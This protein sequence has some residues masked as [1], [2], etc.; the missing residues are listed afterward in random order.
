MSGL[1]EKL[2]GILSN[3]KAMEQIMSLAQ[4]LGKSS[5]QSQPPASDTQSQPEQE[6]PPASEPSDSGLLDTL[7]QID[8]RLI[9]GAFQLMSQYQNNDDGRVALLN[10]LR[11]FV[12]EKRYAKLDKAIQIAKLSRLIRMGLELLRPREDPHV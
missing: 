3:P 1:E 7:S 4:S 5:V 11:P 9:S 2:E 12:K 10:A 6:P 8:P